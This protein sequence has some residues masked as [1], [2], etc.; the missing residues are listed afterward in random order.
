MRRGLAIG[1]VPRVSGIRL[2]YR[3]RNLERVDGVNV[4]IWSPDED[5]SGEVV[6]GLALG[7]PVAGAGEI[8]GAAIGLLG[9]GATRSIEGL[10]LGLAGIGAGGSLRG[11]MLGG[12]GIGAGGTMR[13]L[14]VAGIGIGAGGALQGISV[15]GLGIGSPRIG[16]LAAA[17]A[18][19]AQDTRGVV[20]AP[21]FFRLEND[22]TMRGAAVSSVNLVRGEQ[23][24]LTIGIVNYARR[25][26]GVQ[27]G[28]INIVRDNP[29]GRRV[30]PVVNWGSAASRE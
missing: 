20:L 19:G 2:N 24:G 18:V 23:R 12:V 9:A 15:A 5:I 3:D 7:L 30:L 1:D 17:L 25:L 11:I 28:V 14:Q 4:T 13:R 10:G 26:H 16:G 6:N 29:S 8:N 21:A 22:G 27:V